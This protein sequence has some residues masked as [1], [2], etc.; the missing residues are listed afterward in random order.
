MHFAALLVLWPDRLAAGFP[1]KTGLARTL[2]ANILSL[3]SSQSDKITPDLLG[4]F[5][6]NKPI[7][8]QVLMVGLR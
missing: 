1:T 5:V 7:F 6:L 3:R 4:Y 8:H 2:P